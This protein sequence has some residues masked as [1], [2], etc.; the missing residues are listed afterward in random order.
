LLSGRR[1]FR[2][3]VERWARVRGAGVIAD[4]GIRAGVHVC[5]SYP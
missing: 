4:V 2:T 5:C 3:I 1:A